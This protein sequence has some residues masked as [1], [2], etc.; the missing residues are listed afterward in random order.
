MLL[1][2]S[3]FGSVNLFNLLVVFEHVPGYVPLGIGNRVVTEAGDILAAMEP[4]SRDAKWWCW[5]GLH[6]N[7]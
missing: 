7:S 2:I 4:I 5:E 3:L 6:K 1:L